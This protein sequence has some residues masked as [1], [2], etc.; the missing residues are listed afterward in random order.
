MSSLNENTIKGGPNGD[1]AATSAW[2]S[3]LKGLGGKPKFPER[4]PNTRKPPRTKAGAL[5]SEGKTF[6]DSDGDGDNDS[7]KD[8]WEKIKAAKKAKKANQAKN[9]EELTS[10]DL[11]EAVFDNRPGNFSSI[12][13][14]ILKDKISD[15]VAERKMEITAQAFGEQEVPEDEGDEF[16]PDFDESEEDA[17]IDAA[18]AEIPDED[19]ELD[20]EELNELSDKLKQKYANKARVHVKTNSGK[21]TDPKAREKLLKRMKY[22]AKTNEDNEE[23]DE[24]IDALD[25]DEIEGLYIDLNEMPANEEEDTNIKNNIKP[26]VHSPKGGNSEKISH[27]RK[28]LS[29]LNKMSVTKVKK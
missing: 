21:A 9:E 25:P 29:R 16:D 10:M 2:D 6:K 28:T 27:H 14:I 7:K 19:L 8:K 5:T 17:A 15:L 13:D 11:V 4:G 20:E 18:L 3:K 24:F 22:V 12:F 26:H 1:T 23:V